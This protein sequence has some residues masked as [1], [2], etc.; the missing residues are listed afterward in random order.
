MSST[1][2]AIAKHYRLQQWATQIKECQNRPSTM[3]VSEWCEQQG[4]SIPNYYY[5]LRKVRQA[6]LETS[7]SPS[8]ERHDIVPITQ[9][10]LTA[11]TQNEKSSFLDLSIDGISIRVT[12]A[13]SLSLLEQVLGVIRHVK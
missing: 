6:Y 7:L 4:I 2:T 9:E 3:T 10:L 1:T 5:R 13:T 11:T 12:D 8:E